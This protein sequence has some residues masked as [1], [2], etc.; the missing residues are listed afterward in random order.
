MG[1]LHA[2]TL[3]GFKNLAGSFGKGAEA[4]STAK[5]ALGREASLMGKAALVC[6][7][8]L[9]VPLNIAAHGAALTVKSYRGA[10]RSA[11]GLTALGTAAVVV[12]TALL[13]MKWRGE[14]NDPRGQI[15]E[16][17]QMQGQTGQVLGMLQATEPVMPAPVSRQGYASLQ[18]A[19][20]KIMAAQSAMP[21]GK[22]AAPSAAQGFTA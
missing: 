7:T 19:N 5:A 4:S 3:S 22:V 21:E 13:A 11:P 17:D 10:W 8:P 9:L 1:I 15:L 18:Q 12:P 14:K 16:V 20:P 2:A 6:A